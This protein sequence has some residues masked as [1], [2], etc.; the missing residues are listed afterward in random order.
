MLP[1]V[2]DEVF[3]SMMATLKNNRNSFLRDG[4]KLL[5]LEQPAIYADLVRSAVSLVEEGED[6]EAANDM[7]EGGIR[8]TIITFMALRSQDEADEMNKAWG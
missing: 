8:G 6:D 1:T 4:L 7:M 2:K 5:E 3:M